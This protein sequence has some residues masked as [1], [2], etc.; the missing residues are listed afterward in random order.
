[1]L[2]ET[3]NQYNFFFPTYD[4]G[5]KR[6]KEKQ[7]PFSALNSH[8]YSLIISYPATI[9]N[10]IVYETTESNWECASEHAVVRSIKFE[11][12]SSAT[13]IKKR[14]HFDQELQRITCE[15]VSMAT[16]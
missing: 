2:S 5:E 15:R 13:K 11:Y 10:F 4:G 1:M 16:D 9:T 6:K 3:V 12:I 8:P 14:D 7:L